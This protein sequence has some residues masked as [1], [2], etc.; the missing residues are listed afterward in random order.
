MYGWMEFQRLIKN[1]LRTPVGS[2]ENVDGEIRCGK[3]RRAVQ[4]SLA[5]NPNF[6]YYDRLKI[7][8]LLMTHVIKR[9][10]QLGKSILKIEVVD[11]GEDSNKL[12]IYIEISRI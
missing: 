8:D 11:S 9:V 5:R 12:I 3:A 1:S 2:N 6:S 10:E 7:G 4:L